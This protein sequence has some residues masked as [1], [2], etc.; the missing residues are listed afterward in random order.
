MGKLADLGKEVAA[1]DAE[2][3]M[4]KTTLERMVHAKRSGH[5]N[6]LAWTTAYALVDRWA[7]QA[8]G[9]PRSPNVFCRECRMVLQNSPGLWTD[10]ETE[11]EHIDCFANEE[12]P[13]HHLHYVSGVLSLGTKQGSKIEDW[14]LDEAAGADI[15][16]APVFAETQPS[17]E[18]SD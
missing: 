9:A 10:G 17:D 4:T 7:E 11:P 15:T 5:P 13:V 3:E 8:K 6:P 2:H 1:L 12:G 16:P 14:V 18:I